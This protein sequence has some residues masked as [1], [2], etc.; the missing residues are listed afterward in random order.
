MLYKKLNM[1]KFL[2]IL[3]AI[4]ILL[5]LLALLAMYLSP[6]KMEVVESV[7]MDAPANMV[8]NQVND[9]KKWESW[10]PW[11]KLDPEAVNT[12]SDKTSGVGAQWSWK[13][14]DDVGEG[15]QK[16]IGI[17]PGKA[18]KTSLEFNGMP[19]T[20]FSDWTF[21]PEGDKTKVT[22][23]LDGAE[24]NFFLRPFNLIFKSSVEKSYK[25]GL[26]SIKEIVEKRA[27][28]KIYK[29]YRINEVDVPEKHY[30][31]VRQEIK[32]DNVQQFYS[33]N[34]PALFGKVT[35]AGIEMDGMPGGLFYKWDETNGL[36]DM[37]ASIPLKEDVAVA[38]ATMVTIPSG[39]AIQVD[40]YG[41]YD[42]SVNAHYAIDDYMQ[43]Y[44]ILNNVPIV[45]EYVTDPTVEKDPKKWLTK[46]TYYIAEN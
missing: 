39:R 13:G 21:T 27:Q 32:M 33:R 40:Y 35:A 26:A 24:S 19:G 12:Y 28:E 20:N 18:I 29:G 23:T 17:E 14:N 36:V 4:L 10:S 37:A 2:R 46:I 44:G 11:A 25:D 42:G 31:S 43:D 5:L 22:W 41:D 8:Y 30:L 38:G 9:F 1:K 6:K 7:T 45:E 16:I 3:I 34:L 15:T